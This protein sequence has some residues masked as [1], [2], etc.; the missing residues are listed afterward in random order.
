MK[1][2]WIKG[3]VFQFLFSSLSHNDAVFAVWGDSQGLSLE[4]TAF[5]RR[6][7]N[8]IQRPMPCIAGIVVCPSH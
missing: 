2:A 4:Q 8:T 5:V 3:I 1:K 6:N 7:V